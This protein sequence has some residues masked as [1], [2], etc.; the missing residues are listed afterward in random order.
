MLYNSSQDQNT[1][2]NL[3]GDG[4]TEDPFTQEPE[5]TIEELPVSAILEKK[6]MND[7]IRNSKRKS[8]AAIQLED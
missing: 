4:D 6:E 7:V 5:E 2:I 1:E 8:A 3:I